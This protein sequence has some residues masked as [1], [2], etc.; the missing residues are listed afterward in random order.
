VAGACAGYK[1]EGDKPMDG[2][3]PCHPRRDRE[4]VSF[5]AGLSVHMYSSTVCML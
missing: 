5:R 3:T 1:E 2:K 4:A